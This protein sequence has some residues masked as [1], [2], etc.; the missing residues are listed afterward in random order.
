MNK[1]KFSIVIFTITILIF[2][3]LQ[4]KL[5]AQNGFLQ[6][7]VRTFESALSAITVDEGVTN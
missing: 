3:G 5:F 6:S 4:N 7:A 2:S 1:S